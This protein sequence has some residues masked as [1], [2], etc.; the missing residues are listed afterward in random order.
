MRKDSLNLHSMPK[1]LFEKEILELDEIV[2]LGAHQII[3]MALES[4][5]QAYIKDR[6]HMRLRS[7][8]RA[9]TRNGYKKERPITVGAGVVPVKMPRSR[10]PKGT[11]D[12][13]ISSIVPPYMRR[14]LKID[15]AIPLLYLR[16][17]SN[18]DFIPCLR[19]LLGDGVRGLSPANITRLKSVWRKE[20]DVWRKQDLSDKEYVYVWVDGIHSH[21]SMGDGN[22]CTLVAIGARPDGRK[23]LIAVAGGYRESHESWA[24]L[25]RDLKA[26]G[27]GCPR[28]FIGDGALGFWKAAREVYPNA[29]WQRCWVHKTA[30]ILDKLPKSVQSQAKT[31]IHDIYLAPTK[32]KAEKAYNDFITFCN[33]R[34]P[35]A[36]EC[37]EK[38]KGHL[39]SFYSFPA[40]HWKH[41]RSTNVI[42][43][44]FATVRLRT[45][46]TRGQGTHTTV[47]LMVYKLLEQ[48]SLRWQRLNGRNL[49]LKVFNNVEFTDG[50]ELKD[51]A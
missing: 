38:D 11:K 34:Y 39:F 44:P 29:K 31:M 8:R 27:L 47:L 30:N 20:Y 42:E 12:R 49:L 51:A 10:G 46:K 35:K 21:V 48:T 50:V 22:L 41:I 23:E 7:G 45:K 32:K 15:E 4:E 13:F 6:R 9:F 5:I 17:L 18:G 16:G 25:L 36:I 2:R 24:A 1:E 26:R 40:E 19:K 3:K 43:S 28:L 37:L 14:S 33:G